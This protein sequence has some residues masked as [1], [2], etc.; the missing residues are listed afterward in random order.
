MGA[1]TVMDTPTSAQRPHVFVTGNDY[2]L[3]CLWS[4]GGNWR[5]L[6]MGKPGV[7]NIVGLVGAVTVM[8]TPTSPQRA[9][10]FVT[11][12]DGNVWCRRSDGTS[13][14]WVNMGKPGAAN[15]IALMG[16]VTVMDE[17]LWV[18]ALV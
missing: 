3:W 8:D 11:G 1:V 10:V 2:N 13:W 16:A 15:I 7:A 18:D 12:N 6:N 5:W 4:D 17:N 14:S 9:H